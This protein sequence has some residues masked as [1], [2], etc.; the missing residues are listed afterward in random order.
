MKLAAPTLA[1]VTLLVAASPMAA[2]AAVVTQ[3]IAT[4]NLLLSNVWDLTLT[5]LTATRWSYSI[6]ANATHRPAANM[7]YLEVDVF[8]V[9][10]LTGGAVTTLGV[11][12]TETTNA[13]WSVSSSSQYFYGTNNSAAALLADGSNTLRG[14]I[15]LGSAASPYIWMNF[16]GGESMYSS[17]WSAFRVLPIAPVPQVDATPTPTAEVPEPAALGLVGV[18]LLAAALTRRKAAGYASPR[19]RR[20][21]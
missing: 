19:P 5:E 21:A 15:T 8:G 13:S 7:S 20:L 10:T 9:P 16:Y 18:G 4:Y 11:T 3:P 1:L 6:V 12:G 17:T 2:H 14:T